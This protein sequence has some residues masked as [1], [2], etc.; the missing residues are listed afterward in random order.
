MACDRLNKIK[1]QNIMLF[2]FE[3]WNFLIQMDT[4]YH[5]TKA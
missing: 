4:H 3:L 1:K 2:G 5:H